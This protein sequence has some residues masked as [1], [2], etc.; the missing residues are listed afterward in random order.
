MLLFDSYDV[1]RY[2]FSCHV[3]FLYVVIDS[4]RHFFM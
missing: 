4:V 1:L 2:L 3:F